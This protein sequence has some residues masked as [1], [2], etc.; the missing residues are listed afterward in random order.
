MLVCISKYNFFRLDKIGAEIVS[1]GKVIN[2]LLY[3]NVCK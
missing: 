2:L 1:E 3:N